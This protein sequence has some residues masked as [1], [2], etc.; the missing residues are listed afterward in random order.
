M[1]HSSGATLL[2]IAFVKV[3]NGE[4]DST[5]SLDKGILVSTHHDR[6]SLKVL[7]LTLMY[8]SRARSS[9]SNSSSPLNC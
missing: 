3:E 2:A 9:L 5:M 1:V 6:E 8:K 4:V 7:Q